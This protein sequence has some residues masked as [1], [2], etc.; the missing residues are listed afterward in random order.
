M[1]QEQMKSHAV[2]HTGEQA[3]KQS[4]DL[5][6]KVTTVVLIVLLAFFLLR[7][8]N[9]G[10]NNGPTGGTVADQPGAP[11]ERVAVSLDDDTVMGKKDAPVTI[12]EF[13]DYQC[14][15]CKRFHDDTF[16]QLK[17]KYIDTGK[18]KFVYRDFPLGFHVN[19]QKAAEAAECAGEQGKYWEMHEA[20]FA[21]SQADGTGIAPNDLKVIAKSISLDSAKFDKCL[22]SGAMAAEVQKDLSDGS[23]YGVQGTPA[24]F[25]NGQMISGAQPYSVFEQVIEAELKK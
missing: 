14:P 2:P 24:F 6:W 16:G 12:V 21:K 15:F 1:E 17:S 10:S 18:V 8:G 7:G 9:S 5:F 4:P 3:K 11:A 22:D 25:V 13:S 20:I 23:S 19:A